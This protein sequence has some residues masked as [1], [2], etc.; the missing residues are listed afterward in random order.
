MTEALALIALIIKYG[1]MA[2]QAEQLAVSA[3]P[4]II[5]YS[6]LAYEILTNPTVPTDEQKASVVAAQ[7]DISQ[8]LEADFAAREA[9]ANTPA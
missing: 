3:L 7:D 2:V 9:E 6:K 8:I 4:K 5:A 1:E